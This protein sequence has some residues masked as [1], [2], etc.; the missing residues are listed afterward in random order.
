MIEKRRKT[1]LQ[2]NSVLIS[3][4]CIIRIFRARKKSRGYST[5]IAEIIIKTLEQCTKS[6]LVVDSVWVSP[7]KLVQA[8][9]IGQFIA[10]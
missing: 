1:T 3:S 8:L 2:P 10:N 6:L 7:Q 5:R 9:N 4:Q